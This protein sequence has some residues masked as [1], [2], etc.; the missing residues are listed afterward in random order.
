MVAQL[1]KETYDGS[2]ARIT[3]GSQMQGLVMDVEMVLI[4]LASD[5][6]SFASN[7]TVEVDDIRKLQVMIDQFHDAV[8]EMVKTA[9]ERRMQ[10]DVPASWKAEVEQRS[11]FQNEEEL[12]LADLER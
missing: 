3:A 9:K 8:N 12:D 5:E 10:A 2:K 6:L 7:E 11:R 1:T 4:K